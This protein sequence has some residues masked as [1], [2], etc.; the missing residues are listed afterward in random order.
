[1]VIIIAAAPRDGI[2]QLLLLLRVQKL[3]GRRSPPASKQTRKRVSRSFEK[4]R[5]AS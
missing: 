5:F 2:Y 4:E 3:T 1:V